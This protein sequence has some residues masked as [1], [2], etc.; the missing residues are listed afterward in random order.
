ML[1]T[2]SFY[3]DPEGKGGLYVKIGGTMRI[4]EKSD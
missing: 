3:A 2:Q 4:L 1:F